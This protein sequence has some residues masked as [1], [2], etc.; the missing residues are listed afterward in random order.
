[1]VINAP[2][3]DSNLEPNYE[4]TLQEYIREYTQVIMLGSSI[5]LLVKNLQSLIYLFAL[6]SWLFAFLTLMIIIRI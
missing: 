1:M 2:G 4:Q 6:C 5:V 3:S